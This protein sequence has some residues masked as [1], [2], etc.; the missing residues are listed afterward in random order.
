MG[1]GWVLS[2]KT[3]APPVPFARATRETISNI[4]STN[5]KVE[6][7]VYQEV[8]SEGKGLVKRVL[9][10]TSDALK[11][12]QPIAE[13]SEPGLA[14][15][16]EAA[17]ARL[18]QARA[19]LRTLETGGSAV[20]AADIAGSLNRL[21]GER[22]AAQKN[23][24]A[25]ERLQQKQAATAFEVQQERQTIAGLDAQM[26]TLSEKRSV[27]VGKGELAAAQARV[28]ELEANAQAVRTRMAQDVIA[29]PIAGTVYDLPVRPGSYINPGDVVASLGQLDPVR[30]RVYVDEPEVGRVAQGQG[31]RITWDALAGREWNGVVERRPSEISALGSRQVGEVLCTIANPQHDLIPGTNVNAFILT[32]VVNNALTIPKASVRR[33][34]GTGVYVLQP[35]STVKWQTVKTGASGA[36]RVEILSGLKDGDAIAEPSEQ[37]L[38]DGQKVKPSYQ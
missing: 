20:D 11:A 19:S 35:D 33:D 5:G 13:L 18:A 22:D 10:H 4:L 21:K 23:L 37:T 27:L 6:P 25:L 36:L 3:D 2:R 9:V 29:A 28:Q 7:S 38:H 14:E 16:L 8:R 12:G 17:N 31:V 24:E 32:Q 30:V 26:K 1:A 15:E 34:N